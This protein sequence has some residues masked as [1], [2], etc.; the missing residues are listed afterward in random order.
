MNYMDYGNDRWKI[1]FGEFKGVEKYAAEEIYGTVQQYVP[2]VVIADP[3]QS[4]SEI[5]DSAVIIGT[6]KSNPILKKLADDGVFAPET[7]SEGYSIKVCPSPFCEGRSIVILQGADE[8][9]VLYAV[10]DF[11]H[12][13]LQD[14]LRYDGYHYNVRHRPFIDVPLDWERRSVPAIEHRGLWSWGHV[15]YD[16]R[17]YIDNMSRWKMNTVI[18]WNDRAPL[19]AKDVVEYAHSRGVK[20]IWGYSWCWDEGSDA[21]D[22]K[23]RDEWAKKVVKTYEEQYLPLG[24]D[25]IYFQTFTETKETSRS[26]RSIADLATEWVNYIA[27]KMYERWPDLWIQFGLHASSIRE[28]CD[29]LKKVDDRMSILWEDI[30]AFPYAYDPRMDEDYQPTREYVRHLVKLRGKKERFGAVMKGFTVLNWDLFEHQKGNLIVGTA[31]KQFIADRAKEKEF[32]WKFAAPYWAANAKRLA[33]SM[34]DIADADIADR[35]VT[36]LVEDGLW[37]KESFAAMVTAAELMWDPSR[38]TTELLT[39]IAHCRDC[40]GL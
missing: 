39:T 1:I 21:T 27:D 7:K 17:G 29:T 38:D 9:G 36:A 28:N 12:I 34:A 16:Y 14:K 13:Y 5:K 40:I 26:G 18:I 25:G 31:N 8:N 4:I 22:P 23:V 15:I 32:Y 11:D 35:C 24:G 2:Y 6:M 20:V 33:E 10:R 3:A 19:N 30:G 37:E